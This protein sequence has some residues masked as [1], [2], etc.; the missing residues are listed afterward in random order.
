M[1]SF[2]VALVCSMDATLFGL[3]PFIELVKATGGLA[4][5]CVRGDVGRLSECGQDA[6][7]QSFN[8]LRKS[9]PFLKG[10]REIGLLR[11]RVHGFALVSSS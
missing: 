1:A 11:A 6:T 9:S 7:R 10:T 5:R 3:T 2:G 4:E 8:P